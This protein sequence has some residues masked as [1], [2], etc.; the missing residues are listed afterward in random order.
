MKFD[1][2]IVI[3]DLEASCKTFNANEIEESNIIEIGAVRLDKK[4]LEI[5]G[6]FTTLIKPKDFPILQE[7]SQIVGITPEMVSEAPFF[8]MAVIPF[9]E[10]YGARNKSILAGWGL[11]YD[12]PLLRKEFRVFGLDYNRY[13]VGGGLDVRSLAIL[14]MAQHNFDTSGISPV[15]VISKMN[16][17]VDFKYHRALEDARAT[18]MILRKI[19]SS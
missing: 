3:F 11:Y 2:D 16:P 17:E 14:W 1:S 6:E 10:W 9:L 5:T 18:A 15:R 8:N 4:T 7:I 19:V 13:F 12:L